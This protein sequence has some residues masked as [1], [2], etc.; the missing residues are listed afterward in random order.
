MTCF[1][2]M[3][4]K[5]TSHTYMLLA[6]PELKTAEGQVADELRAVA[7]PQSAWDAWREIVEQEI[8]PDDDESGY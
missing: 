7:A 3:E 6:F 1:S 5:I 2:L 4:F 8:L